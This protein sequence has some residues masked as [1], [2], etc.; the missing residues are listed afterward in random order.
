[1]RDGIAMK[2]VLVMR[3]EAFKFIRRRLLLS[4]GKTLG[5]C[6]AYLVWKPESFDRFQKR[7]QIIH[8]INKA[9]VDYLF[10]GSSA[11]LRALGRCYPV[12]STNVVS[13]KSQ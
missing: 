3:K 12:H 9:V 11:T 7:G 2:I 8:G 6:R 10:Q 1:M 5:S 4:S 13:N